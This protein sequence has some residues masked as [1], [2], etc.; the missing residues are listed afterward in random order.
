MSQPQA[1]L[2]LLILAVLGTPAFCSENYYGRTTGTHFCTSIPEGKNLT[3][4]RMYV[5]N[6]IIM[7]VQMKH[8]DQ[9]GSLYGYS[10]GSLEE[11]ELNDGEDIMS[12]YGSYNSYMRQ[13]VLYTTRPRDKIFGTAKANNE[14]TDYPQDPSHVLLGFCGYYVRGWL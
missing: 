13:I 14:F 7:G 1:M 4:I 3:R 5:R 10:D 2:L 12:L 9:W 8:G 6:N 11:L